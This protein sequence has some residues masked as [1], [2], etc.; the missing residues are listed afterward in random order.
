MRRV[1]MSFLTVLSLLVAPAAAGAMG[2][3]TGAVYGTVVDAVTE[4]PVE[5]VCVWVFGPGMTETEH[6]GFTN[7]DGVY[8][9]SGMAPG[10]YT[11][12]FDDCEREAYDTMQ[13]VVQVTAGNAVKADEYLALADGVGSIVGFA[14]DAESH[15]GVQWMC[16][17]L[18]M[19]ADDILVNGTLTGEDGG[20]QLYGP[21]G[22]Y[23]VRFK[24]CEGNN[25]DTQWYDGA[26]GWEGSTVVTIVANDFVDGVDADLIGEAIPDTS[27]IWGYVVD[28]ATAE[29][30]A[31]YCVSV[32]HGDDKIKTVL[33][34]P[35]GGYEIEVDAVEMTVKA[36]ACEGA[37]DLGTVWYLDALELGDADYFVPEGGEHQL[38]TIVVGD[39]RFSDTIDSIFHEDIVW[40][41]EEGVTSGCNAD[42]TLFCPGEHV[43]RAQM[44]AF[45][46]RALGELLEASG[47]ADFSDDDLSIFEKD[48]EWLASVG[49][50][51]GCGDGEFCPNDYV[52]RAQM[53]AFL[54]RALEDLLAANGEASF[55]DDNQSIFE[56]DI[57]WLA[58]TGVTAGC[59]DGLF[60][61][62]DYVTR[63]HMAAFLH[64]A[65]GDA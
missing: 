7:W 11:L 4:R 43:T 25:Y 52:T 41:A 6:S 40:L 30:V 61:P 60:C 17:D 53:A 26:E 1:V 38:D 47:E 57:E 18:F 8:E 55:S 16:V 51:A 54:H 42:Q 35:D 46:H 5:G 32:Y 39:V 45:L 10:Q 15:E 3:G 59:D 9:I 36:W 12:E 2:E 64:R 62:N 65:L 22:D 19:A 14:H 49:V 37:E 58:S 34:G 50:T 33:T 29:G 28:G 56:K 63:A 21:A 48:I 27:V 20:Y 13:D 23:R 24:S 44:A 31:E